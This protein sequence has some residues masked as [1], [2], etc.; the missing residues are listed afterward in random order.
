MSWLSSTMDKLSGASM[1]EDLG[2]LGGRWDDAYGESLGVQ[3]ELLQQGR[4]MT[5]PYS[6]ANLRQ[7]GMM[8]D[9]SADNMAEAM[10]L[11]GR[12]AQ[13]AGGAP[14]GVM[15]QQGIAGAQ[16]NEAA[17]LKAFNQYLQGQ[18]SAGQ[19]LMGDASANI[20]SMQGNKFNM[21]ESQNQANKQIDQ[22]SAKWGL[23][24]MSKA[25]NFIPGVGPAA[26]QA[27]QM[28]GGMGGGMA[29]GGYIPGISP[30]P[31]PEDSSKKLWYD[32]QNSPAMMQRAI[33]NMN[34]PAIDDYNQPN[35]PSDSVPEE[36]A[37]EPQ[38]M[39]RTVMGPKGP[40]QIGTRMGGELIG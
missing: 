37:P 11:Q 31:T 23:N 15:A 33:D 26:S 22:Q 40:M 19:G 24:M 18:Q 9:D 28:M 36:P 3:K 12:N 34:S 7:K 27:M 32:G 20:A 8:K 39:L 6:Q 17:N 25:A 2:K 35:F 13:M 14:I 29:E 21:M 16:K 10:R 30:D 38:G 1:K 4:D 5:D